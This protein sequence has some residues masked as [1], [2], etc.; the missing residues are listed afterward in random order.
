M[1][2]YSYGKRF[3]SK[4]AWANRKEGDPEENIQHTEHGESLKS[5][6]FRATL[7]SF[8]PYS[9]Q[10]ASAYSLDQV[11]SQDK[12][13]SPFQSRQWTPAGGVRCNSTL[14]LTSAL[15]GGW[16]VSATPRPLSPRLRPG[17]HC[18]RGWVGCRSGLDGCKKS[19]PHRDSMPGPS[20][21]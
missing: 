18:T 12:R 1:L 15:D 4:I 3:G 20:I 6:I 2:R 5:R 13:W 7:G 10:L 16:V 21:P 8:E 11:L 9:N 14:F 17:A 19:L